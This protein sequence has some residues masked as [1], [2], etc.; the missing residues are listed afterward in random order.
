MT[1]T[2][3]ASALHVGHVESPKIQTPPPPSLRPD[4]RSSSRLHRPDD[5][6]WAAPEG[7]QAGLVLSLP[8]GRARF[9]HWNASRRRG[10][11]IRLA[12][13]G[14]SLR[15]SSA[16]QVAAKRRHLRDQSSPPHELAP[17]SH[18]G[19]APLA[20]RT[21]GRVGL[22]AMDR[23]SRHLARRNVLAIYWKT[24]STC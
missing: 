19:K 20:K 18:R 22:V 14:G 24:A 9:H 4:V 8:D 6:P 3:A 17:P 13:P 10:I 12:L 21:S 23:I 16:R 7:T 5:R 1:L 11:R 2:L 15:L